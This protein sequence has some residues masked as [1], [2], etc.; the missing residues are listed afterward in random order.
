LLA[1]GR[2]LGLL[3]TAEGIEVPEQAEILRALGCQFAQ[4]YLY[5]R[6]AA[7]ADVEHLLGPAAST[8][9]SRH[10]GSARD[11]ETLISPSERGTATTLAVL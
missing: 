8:D 10:R 1:L 9:R 3:V 6:P 5:A 11:D 4:G 7:A 2:D